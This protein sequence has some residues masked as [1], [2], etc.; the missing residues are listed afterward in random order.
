VTYAVTPP[1]ATVYLDGRE[2]P[3]G[4]AGALELPADGAAHTLRATARGHADQSE[5]FTADTD[6]E[7]ALTLR[8]RGRSGDPGTARP[9]G[10]AGGTG[11]TGGR[12]PIGV[13]NPWD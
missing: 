9:P 11:G 10:G 5:D 4:A 13:V 1:D 2:V 3:G 7:I 6:R 12:G 8:R